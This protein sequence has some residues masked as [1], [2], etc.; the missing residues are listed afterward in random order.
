MKKIAV[1]CLVV[2]NIYGTQEN[3]IAELSL[4]RH[5]HLIANNVNA[6]G[7]ITLQG[8]EIQNITVIG[9]LEGRH[10]TFGE[11]NLIGEMLLVD[12]LAEVLHIHNEVIEP[13]DRPVVLDESS[14]TGD[15]IFTGAF[16][17]AIIRN[18][19]LIGGSVVNG[20]IIEE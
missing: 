5:R 7:D 14:V 4:P 6:E 18:G 17:R 9:T 11:I 13:S 20:E 10:T 16:G 8:A 1:L 3:D 15:V 19:S 2:L 12:S